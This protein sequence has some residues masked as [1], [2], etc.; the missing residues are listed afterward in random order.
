MPRSHPIEDYRNFGIM[1]HI[2]AGKTTTTE[3]VLY[4]SGKS[5]KIGEVHDGAATMDFMEQEQERGI[6][7][8]SAAT[9]AFWNGKRLN[10][11]D[12]PGHVDLPI[13]VE[14]S[15]RVLDGAVCGLDSNQGVEPQTG[16]VW[17]QGDK[18]R[19][20]SLVSANKMEKTGA[21]FYKGLEDIVDRLGAKPIAIQLPIGSEN[22]F[23]GL[24]DYVRMKVWSVDDEVHGAPYKDLNIPADLVDKA[25]E[26]REKLLEAAV[27]LDD[28]SLAAY[29]DGKEPDE[30]TLKRLIRKAVLTSAFF[31]VLCGSAFKNKGV[32]PLLDAVVDYLPSPVDVPA[33]KGIDED[34]NEVVRLPND[35]EPLALLAFK[36]MDDPFV[37]TITF[38]R[39]YSGTLLSGTGVINSTR[40]RKERIGRM[41]LMH[42]NNREDIKEA[43]AGD[44]VALAGLKEARTGDTLCDP[45]K[46][47][48]LEK[49][50]FPEPVIEIAIEP[51]SKADQE[52]LGV[53][54]AKL[55]AEDPSFRVS[56]DQESGQTILKGMGE[57][58]LGIKVDILRRTYKVDANIGA[59]QV[60]FREKITKKAEVKYTHKKQT[61][62]TGQFARDK[63]IVKLNETD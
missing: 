58:H 40:D 34:G 47:V 28:D 33:I 6:T 8:T 62:G 43:Y 35:K 46:S 39:I 2:D 52:K 29:L 41:L 37:G 14:R 5:H 49:M 61:G 9:T 16:T 36:I 25:R 56:T 27:E 18:Y 57:L 55:A 42:A 21:D 12:A 38:C 30:A 3:R 32:Q 50:E 13:E 15:L 23:K 44:I 54:L 26:Y 45:D 51:K 59:L 53:A 22:N 11:I 60:A 4:Y 17:R 10:I 31:P 20:P 1:A 19:V 7:I 24:V 48:I 63:F